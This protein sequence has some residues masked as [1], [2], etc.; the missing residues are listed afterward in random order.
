M[1]RESIST[2]DQLTDASASRKLMGNKK[3]KEDNKETMRRWSDQLT[4]ASATP[5]HPAKMQWDG[6]QVCKLMGTS[7]QHEDFTENMQFIYMHRNILSKQ[8]HMNAPI[9]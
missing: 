1:S 2:S 8:H 3:N 7:E 9:V 4:D 5:S 6:P